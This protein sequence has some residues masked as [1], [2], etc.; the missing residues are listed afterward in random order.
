MK[1]T[2]LF[3]AL[4]LSS[5]LCFGQNIST[6]AG[7]GIAGF[8]GDGGA[9]TSAKINVPVGVAF[10]AS[11]SFWI[12]DFANGRIRKVNGASSNI[13][14]AALP[15][16]SGGYLIEPSDVALDASTGNIYVPD[17][18]NNV[19]YKVT[20]SGVETVVAGTGTAGYNGDGISATSSELNAPVGVAVVHNGSYTDIYIADGGNNAIRKVTG[21]TGIISTVAGQESPG[22]GGDGGPATQ[23]WI[24]TPNGIALDASG[25]MYIA[26]TGNNR[27][28]KVTASTGYIS[29]IAGNGTA[30][31]SGDGGAAT[32]A[33]LNSPSYVSVDASGNFYIADQSN[34]RI[35]KVTVSTGNISTV[36]GNGTAGYSGDGGAATSAELNAPASV[37][38]DGSGNLLIGDMS[39]YRVRLVGSVCTANA[40]T[41]KT[42]H[43]SDACCIPQYCHGVTIGTASS[44]YTYNWTPCNSTLS[45]CTVAQPT[46]S[47]CSTTSYTL[48]VSGSCFAHSDIVVVSQVVDI[49]CN[50]PAPRIAV[51][52][53][54][55]L[56][57][58]YPNPS[59]GKIMIETSEEIQN[60]FITDIAG[61]KVY[62]KSTI[63]GSNNI[64]LSTEP[65]G[66]YLVKYMQNGINHI[67]KISIE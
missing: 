26:D 67:E 5:S 49:C 12:A 27:I 8:S 57:R 64:D 29:T 33:K 63:I 36:A 39:N 1:K 11:G 48:T 44:G 55:E 19:V 31:F 18:W 41:D 32:S 7:N 51:K 34:N 66:I 43:V 3:L 42:N 28:R 65:K 58:I 62:E 46:A 47:P 59:N 37:K 45:S 20:P 50:S 15:L 25:N 21:S 52:K 61:R 35:R 30:G 4:G 14:T 6:V 17:V 24:R 54:D 60:L 13:S 23:A 38:V 9:A 10:D 40:G 56:I 2:N 53:E 16:G 22:Y